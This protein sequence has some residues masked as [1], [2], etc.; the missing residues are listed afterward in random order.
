MR[1]KKIVH[2][3]FIDRVALI[4]AFVSAFALYPQLFVL[5]TNV[6]VDTKSF[7]MVSFILIFT[8]SILWLWYGVHQRVVPLIV[9]S[10]LN[11]G[12]AGGIILLLL[13]HRMF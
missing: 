2:R 9:S 4:N 8:S 10:L 3:H 13:F 6:H 5:L 1:V 12:A 7:S 11:A